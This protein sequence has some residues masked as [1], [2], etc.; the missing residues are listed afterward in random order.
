MCYLFTVSPDINALRHGMTVRLGTSHDYRRCLEQYQGRN[1]HL[2][3][4]E[5]H[6][7]G[8]DHHEIKQE[9]LNTL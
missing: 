7:D 3:T 4:E 6:E 9:H 8:Y 2:R 5:E 1:C